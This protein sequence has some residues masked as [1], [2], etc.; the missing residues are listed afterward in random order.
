MKVVI[1]AIAKCENEYINDWINYHL[2]LGVDEIYLYDNNDEDYEPVESRI[3]INQGKVVIQKI[4]GLRTINSYDK[5]GFQAK[6]YNEFYQAHCHEFDW[7][8]FL[9]I[10]EFIVLKKWSDI[11]S[12]L[13][14]NKFKNYKVIRLNWHMFGD[15]GLIERDMSIPIYKGITKRLRGHIN[16]KDGKEF[17]RGGLEGVNICSCHYCRIN[18]VM[19]RQ[20]MP[21]GKPTRG[22]GSQL[23]GD[24]G[25]HNCEEAYINHYKTKTLSE[26]INQKMARG[27]DAVFIDRKID[28]DYYWELNKKTPEKLEYIRKWKGL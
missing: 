18:R 3:K 6:L 12:F 22:K 24:L 5:F 27:T 4:P 26:F 13:N 14:D 2:N 15:D 17:V 11:K 1:C 28:F 10:D 20:V 7:I 19:P 9:D 25:L 21:D 23:K 8:G 16:E